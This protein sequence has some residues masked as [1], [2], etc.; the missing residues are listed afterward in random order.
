MDPLH[1]DVDGEVVECGLV[2]SS[3]TAAPGVLPVPLHLDELDSLD[4]LEDVT[5]LLVDLGVPSEVAGVVV[6]DLRLEL[7]VEREL[8]LLDELVHILSEVVD[9]LA[10]LGVVVS[11]VARDGLVTACAGH[12]HVLGTH[13]IGLG[14]DLLSD[15]E[16]EVPDTGPEQR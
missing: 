16:G 11:D 3:G 7:V 12:D 10:A 1:R 8:P 13:R 6:G 2:S 15:L 9:V 14:D 5:G 4:L